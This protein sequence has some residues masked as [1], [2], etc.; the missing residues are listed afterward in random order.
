MQLLAGGRLVEPEGG[1]QGQ[2]YAP[3]VLAGITPAMRIWQEEVFGPVMAIIEAGDDDDAVRLANDCPFGL[4]SAIFSGSQ[5]RAR[6]IAS[7]LQV[8]SFDRHSQDHLGL[9]VMAAAGKL[10]NRPSLLGAS[11][12][13][14]THAPAIEISTVRQLS[15]CYDLNPAPASAGGD[16]FNK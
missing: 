11:C 15:S 13:S 10:C 7:R 14:S 8:H 6:A 4:G 1:Q 5:A 3:T 12:A 16:V 2:Y 9:Y